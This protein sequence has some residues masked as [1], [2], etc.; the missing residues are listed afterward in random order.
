MALAARA[1]DARA[2]LPALRA[3]LAGASAQLAASRPTAVN[4]GWALAR[5]DEVIAA[6]AG[7]ARTSSR[8]ALAALARRIHDD[9]VARCRAMGPTAPRCSRRAPACS[10]TA[11]PARSRPAAT[12]PRSASCARRTRAIPGLHVWVGETRP[13]LQGARLTAWELARGRDPAHADRRRRGRAAVRAR[14]GRRRRLRRRPHRAQRRRRQQDRLVH[15]LGARGRARRALLRRRA[16]VDDRPRD[17][18]RRGDPDRGARARRGRAARAAG[19][20]ARRHA[21]SRTPPS[22]SRPAANITAI[23]TEA[24]VHRAPLR[25]EPA[26]RRAA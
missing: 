20:R 6:A 12:A 11:T 8:A 5:C 22:T 17:R 13:L 10:R 26:G 25:A 1:L 24:G 14:A 23:V 15:A 16:V 19:A 9:E 3:E 18:E 2:T 4:L 7:H 21:R